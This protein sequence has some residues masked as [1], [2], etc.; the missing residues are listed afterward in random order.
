[1]CQ[2]STTAGPHVS[3]PLASAS[4]PQAAYVEDGIKPEDLKPEQGVEDPRIEE[5]SPSTV[6][7]IMRRYATMAGRVLI[8]IPGA[9][10][11][12][13]VDVAR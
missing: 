6:V 11:Q 2:A 10:Y 9:T 13:T 4:S 5:N 7:G 1:M 12:F 3:R 8:A